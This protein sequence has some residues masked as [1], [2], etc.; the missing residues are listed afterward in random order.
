MLYKIAFCDEKAFS[1]FRLAICVVLAFRGRRRNVEL[2]KLFFVEYLCG[3]LLDL[4]E[5][6]GIDL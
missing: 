6:Q 2:W 3:G 4:R 1:G 5:A